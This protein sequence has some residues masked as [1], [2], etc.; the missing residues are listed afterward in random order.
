[1]QDAVEMAGE[2]AMAKEVVAKV[3]SATMPRKA[4]DTGVRK[5]LDGH[6][7]T[8]SS[9]NKGKDGDKLRN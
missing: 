8:I 9:G 4:S 2:V 7:F 5:D 1:V 3:A 6:I